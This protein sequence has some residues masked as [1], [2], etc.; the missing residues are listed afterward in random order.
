MPRFD[1]RTVIVTG[2]AGGMGVSHVRAFHGEG[3]MV[4][5]A[6]PREDRARALV[7]ELGERALAVRLDV[8]DEKD[9]AAAVATAEEHF[10][11]VS[12]LVNNAGVQNPAATLERTKRS[13]WDRTFAVNVTGSWLGIRA[14]TPSMRR[15]G[16]GSIINIA[17][18]MAHGGTPMFGPYVA[19]KWA[20]RGLTRTAALELARDRIRVN[21][22][23]PGV[24]ATPLITEPNATGQPAIADSFSPEPF[25]VQRLGEPAEVS[26][27]LLYLTSQQATFA[28]GAEFVLDGGLLLGPAL[29]SESAA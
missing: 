1:G 16:G 19:S 18:V 3:A 10:G 17:S 2:G 20:V 24:V 25:A 11:P 29:P 8:T 27:L 7:D 26:T 12:V 9:W 22:I 5:V 21:S 6:A 15:G 4:V 14:V 23:H 28:T 13:V